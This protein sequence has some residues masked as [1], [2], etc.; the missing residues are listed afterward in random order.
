MMYSKVL[1]YDK[2]DLFHFVR[3]ADRPVAEGQK[4]EQNSIEIRLFCRRE[5]FRERRVC[6]RFC[7]IQNTRYETRDS[8]YWEND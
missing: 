2:R 5:I 3:K 7:A 1:Q 8:F 6:I 4:E